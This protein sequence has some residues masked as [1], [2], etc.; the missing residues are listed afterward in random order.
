MAEALLRNYAG[1]RYDVYSAG[2]GPGL[3]NPLLTTV[4][5]EKRISMKGHY[6]KGIDGFLGYDF[7]F[8]IV[9]CSKAELVCPSFPAPCVRLYWL[10]RQVRTWS[11]VERRFSA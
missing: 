5:G 11:G 3:M 4:M 8:V 7:G 1:D 10:I 2:L 9:V 6:S